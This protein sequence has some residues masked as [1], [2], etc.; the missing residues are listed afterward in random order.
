MLV[1][2]SAMRCGFEKGNNG[3]TR[4][5]M[6]EA[7]VERYN[8]RRIQ[9]EYNDFIHIQNA[10]RAASKQKRNDVDA[11]RPR[12]HGGMSAARDRTEPASFKNP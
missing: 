9:N 5:L 10:E 6:S 11:S 8:L 12:R 1:R 7:A 3:R 4:G 2:R